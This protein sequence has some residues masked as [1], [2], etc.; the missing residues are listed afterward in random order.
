VTRDKTIPANG[1]LT[2]NVELEDPAV[3]NAA[4]ATT[5]TSSVPIIVERA[6]YWPFAPPQW[7]EAHNSFGVTATTTRWGLAEGEAGGTQSKQTYI[8][9]ANPNVTDA[10][11]SIEF[12]AADRSFT[13]TFF[14]PGRSRFNVSVGSGLMVD[15]IQNETFG[16]V[17][18][19]DQPIAVERAIYANVPGQI[20]GAGSNATATPLQ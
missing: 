6:Q 2:L 17:I 10:N 3:A 12:L 19:S 11:V 13:Q 8:L 5:V 15:G 9:L 7:F 1:R 16:A 20:W 18:T 14:V 4:V